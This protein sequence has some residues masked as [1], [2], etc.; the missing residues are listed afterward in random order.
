M[1]CSQH[2]GCIQALLGGS[3]SNGIQQHALLDHPSSSWD[4]LVGH[5][6]GMD[7]AG[8]TYGVE[9]PQMLAKVKANDAEAMR[10][11][12]LLPLTLRHTAELD[13]LHQTKALQQSTM[14]TMH[15]QTMH[16]PQSW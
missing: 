2:Y 15:D 9:S 12:L 13:Q 14:S 11:H 16:M 1:C 7:H 6:L 3:S 4:I 5:Y 8:H 10:V